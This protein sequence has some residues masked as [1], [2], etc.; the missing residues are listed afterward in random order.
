MVNAR[1]DLNIHCETGKYAPIGANPPDLLPSPVLN[2]AKGGLP[3]LKQEN[4]PD[5]I[6]GWTRLRVAGFT[7]KNP[8][9]D[10]V[11]CISG[12]DLT[13]WLHVSADEIVSSMSFLTLRLGI[14]LEG[15]NNPDLDAL[16]ETL[17]R[18]ER[19]ASHIRIAQI[20]QN[21]RAITG[22]L[23]G[24]ELAAARVYWLGQQVAV[25][26]HSGYST[27]LSAQGVPCTSQDLYLCEARGLAA[28]AELL[29][30]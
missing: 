2:V 16:S 6:G 3:G 8:N 11:I 15:S 17:S 5:F 25:L 18:P 7:K 27:A 14:L 12:D 20:N 26:G 30:Y 1:H 21:H 24:A 19:L 13:H 29:E 23:M 10:G 9:W 4:P 22:H 28:L